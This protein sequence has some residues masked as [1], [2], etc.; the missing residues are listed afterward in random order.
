MF[1]GLRPLVKRKTKTTAALARDHLITIGDSGLITV[2]GGKWTTYRKMAED[3]VDLALIRSGWEKRNCITAELKLS[4]HD[5]PVL[6][7]DISSLNDDELKTLVKHAV[8]GEMCMTVEDFL[9]RRTRLLLLDAGAAIE[10]APK[11]A[12]LMAEEMN[13]DEDWIKEQI[14]N[15]NSI[16]GNYLPIIK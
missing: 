4:G 3:V 13:K 9:S 12:R 8:A 5:K 1:A 11:V 14:N 10:I 15:F 2:T 7:A 16:A 6:P